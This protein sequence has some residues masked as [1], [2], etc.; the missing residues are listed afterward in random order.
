MLKIETIFAKRREIAKERLKNCE[1]CENYESDIGR[2]K[3]CGCFMKFK[4]VFPS[5]KCPL[6][7]WEIYKDGE[8]E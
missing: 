5:A 2:C 7:K 6:N 8:K 4:T 3:L 1:T